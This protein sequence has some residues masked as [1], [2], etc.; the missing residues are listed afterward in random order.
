MGAGGEHEGVVDEFHPIRLWVPAEEIQRDLAEL[1][2]RND[3]ALVELRRLL[4]SYGREVV[5]RP[6]RS[7]A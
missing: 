4:D 1:T 5:R 6:R 2:A 7:A 3:A